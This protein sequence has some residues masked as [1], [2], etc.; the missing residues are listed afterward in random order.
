MQELDLNKK[1]NGH[2]TGC[3][4]YGIFIEFNEFE[5]GFT[6]LLH[7]SKMNPEIS[8]K[9][10]E[11]NIKAGDQIEFYIAEISKDRIICTNE[12]P[13]EKMKKIQNFILNS[14]DKMLES[15]VA[16][17]MNFGVIVNINDITGLI[18]MKEFKRN[19][20]MA[21]NFVSGDK[22]NVLFDEYKD[23]KLVFKLEN[24]KSK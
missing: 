19:K 2:V 14:K 17:V 7:T 1:Y 20:I 22:I 8:K 16:A 9:F 23:D 18:P 21:N 10:Y 13:E 3:S 5:I 4:K 6:G 24:K 12:S 11:R 15:S